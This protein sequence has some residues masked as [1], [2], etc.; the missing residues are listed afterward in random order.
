MESQKSQTEKQSPAAKPPVTSCRKK[1]N[2]EASFLED[3]KDHI[4]EFINASMDEHKTCFKKTIQ[5]VLPSCSGFNF[6]AIVAL[7]TVRLVYWSSYF[8]LLSDVWNVK[9]CRW[10]KLW[11]RGSWERSAP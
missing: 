7:Y 2:E 9:D 6:Y 1:K 8:G 3:V 11:S 4:D 10:T 5:K